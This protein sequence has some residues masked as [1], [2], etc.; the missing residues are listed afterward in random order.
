MKECF[1][2]VRSIIAKN[3]SN[4]HFVMNQPV[5]MNRS[6]IFN[7]ETTSNSSFLPLVCDQ[8]LQN[9]QA[10]VDRV[11]ARNSEQSQIF[12]TSITSSVSIFTKSAT[13]NF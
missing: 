7:T 4:M 5:L 2:L 8:Q 12:L 6:A 11:Q 10:Q 9:L 1:L 13:Y 3:K